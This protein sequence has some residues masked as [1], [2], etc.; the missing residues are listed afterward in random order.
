MHSLA[1]SNVHLSYVVQR[2]G[3][4]AFGWRPPRPSLAARLIGLWTMVSQALHQSREREAARVIR[5]YAHL[6]S[7]AENGSL[8]TDLERID[9]APRRERSR[10]DGEIA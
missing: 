3:A 5:R 9:Q 4:K 1:R 2:E 10:F 8:R 6:I 7:E